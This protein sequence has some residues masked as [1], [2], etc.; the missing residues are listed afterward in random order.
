[1]APGLCA[2]PPAAE[3]TETSMTAATD[4][5]VRRASKRPLKVV[6]RRG[7]EPRTGSLGVARM[8]RENSGASTRAVVDIAAVASKSGRW[9]EVVAGCERVK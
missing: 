4:A 6:T 3:V 8:L 1:M 5:K 7:A 2:V 9:R